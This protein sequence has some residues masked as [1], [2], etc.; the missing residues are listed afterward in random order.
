MKTL[1]TIA[2]VVIAAAFATTAYGNAAADNAPEATAKE[3]KANPIDTLVV[4][5]DPQMHCSGCENR[6]KSNIRFVKGTKRI[7]TDLESQTVTIIYD[8]RK[9]S[10]D[11]Y[12][13]AFDK[14]GYTITPAAKK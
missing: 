1:T 9:A 12:T 13:K 10:I 2:A 3:V 11:D 5:P 7:D 6:I 14:I 4:T 8:S